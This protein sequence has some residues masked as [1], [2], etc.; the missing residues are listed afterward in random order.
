MFG[1]ASLAEILNRMPSFDAPAACASQGVAEFLG[2]QNNPRQF[3]LRQSGSPP[4]LSLHLMSCSHLL[5]LLFRAFLHSPKVGS[6]PLKGHLGTIRE[7]VLC[8]C[9]IFVLDVVFGV[10]RLRFRGCCCY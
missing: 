10:I 5:P 8:F 7:R 9:S 1:C 6:R 3:R 4:Y 2:V